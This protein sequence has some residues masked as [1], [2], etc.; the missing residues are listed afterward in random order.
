VANKEGPKPA[1]EPKPPLVLND[2]AELQNALKKA[3][4][5]EFYLFDLNKG[6]IESSFRSSNFKVSLKNDIAQITGYKMCILLTKY[7]FDAKTFHVTTCVNITETLKNGKSLILLPN[8]YLAFAVPAT[9]EEARA[10]SDL[11][12][13]R[14]LKMTVV[15]RL[16]GFDTFEQMDSSEKPLTNNLVKTEIIKA[17]FS[18]E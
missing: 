18:P 4:A 9:M 14:K 13:E 7:D 1:D 3:K 5:D 10:W 6:S 12:K 16:K 8:Y 11:F 15:F 17:S 2:H